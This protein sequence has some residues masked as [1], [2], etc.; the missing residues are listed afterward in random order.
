MSRFGQPIS[1]ITIRCNQIDR[2][3]RERHGAWWTELYVWIVEFERHAS[4][5][6]IPVVRDLRS[7]LVG[8]CGNLAI[9]C[10]RLD[11]NPVK[12]LA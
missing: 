11:R 7:S 2:I 5:W 6:A 10:L 12:L 8:G 3:T 1:K 9:L 4:G